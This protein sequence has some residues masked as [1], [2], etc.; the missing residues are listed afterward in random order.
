MAV[1]LQAIRDGY[2]HA[3]AVHLGERMVLQ[4]LD[5]RVNLVT[6]MEKRVN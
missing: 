1:G 3:D 4:E 6:P 2:F 5:W